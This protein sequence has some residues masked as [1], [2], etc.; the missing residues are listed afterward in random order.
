M[1]KDLEPTEEQSNKRD[2]PVVAVVVPQT[3]DDEGRCK[4]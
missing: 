1:P 4:K 2:V 3:L